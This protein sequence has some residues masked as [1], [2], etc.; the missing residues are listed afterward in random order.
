MQL[1]VSKY[2]EDNIDFIRFSDVIQEIHSNL[3]PFA[4]ENGTV[5]LVQLKELSW[6]KQEFENIHEEFPALEYEDIESEVEYEDLESEV[7][8][9]NEETKA[10]EMPTNELE[11]QENDSN[12]PDNE[13]SEQ[14]GLNTIDFYNEETLSDYASA[15]NELESEEIAAKAIE[16]SEI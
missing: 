3:S 8:N 7:E 11:Y 5:N 14:D 4:L 10:I 2:G 9:G 6:Y 1:A 13:I 15:L 16:Y 12:I